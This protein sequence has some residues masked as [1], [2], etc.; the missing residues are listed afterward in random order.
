MKWSNQ[1]YLAVFG[2][3]ALLQGCKPLLDRSSH[4]AEAPFVGFGQGAQR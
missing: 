1:S 4:F 2:V 3:V